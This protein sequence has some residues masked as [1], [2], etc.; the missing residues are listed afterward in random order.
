MKYY[1]LLVNVACLGEGM[2][3]QVKWF[4]INDISPL[5]YLI[6]YCR[7][8]GTVAKKAS[9]LFPSLRV[10]VVDD[11]FKN[12]KYFKA[13]VRNILCPMPLPTLFE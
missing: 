1:K 7:E 9:W 2:S 4:R 13:K 3:G 10:R 8:S 12:G 6:C 11:K 5:L